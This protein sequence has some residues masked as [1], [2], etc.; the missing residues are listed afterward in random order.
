[1]AT[2]RALYGASILGVTVGLLVLLVGVAIGQNPVT[3]GGGGL[4]LV[5]VAV[6]TRHIASLPEPEGH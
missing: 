2:E 6:M 4:I 1:M 5:S 3:F